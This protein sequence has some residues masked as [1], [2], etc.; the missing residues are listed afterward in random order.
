MTDAGTI[1]LVEDDYTHVFI[2]EAGFRRHGV[3]NPIH[4][5][6]SVEEAQTYLRGAGMYGNRSR[7][8]L[9]CLIL[10]DLDVNRRCGAE[11]LRWLQCDPRLEHIPVVAFGTIEAPQELQPIYDAGANACFEKRGGL[12]ELITTIKSLDFVS[13]I[14]VRTNQGNQR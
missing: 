6:R 2:F 8:P 1:L 3:S 13:Q 7:F 14:L 12:D 11:L 10:L 5:A 4:M 9:P